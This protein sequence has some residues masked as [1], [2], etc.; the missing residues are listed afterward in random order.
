[1]V[2]SRASFI[3]LEV[4]EQVPCA[5]WAIPVLVDGTTMQLTVEV[6]EGKA[7]FLKIIFQQA[8]PP[9]QSQAALASHCFRSAVRLD[10]RP[11]AQIP[12]IYFSDLREAEAKTQTWKTNHI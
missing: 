8:V 12:G 7:T 1:M 11:Q 3:P 5:R 4:H 6:C 9:A 2:L 10:E